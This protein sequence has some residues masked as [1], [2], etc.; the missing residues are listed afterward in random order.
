[1]SKIPHDEPLRDA[2]SRDLPHQAQPGAAS[3]EDDEIDLLALAGTLWRGRLWIALAVALGILLA[4]YYAYFQTTSVYSASTTVALQREQPQVVDFQSVVSGVSTDSASM[5]TEIEIMRSA[6]LLT[7]VA[8]ALDLPQYP[9][10][11]PR[12]REEPT[13][14]LGKAVQ[15]V[16]ELFGDANDAVVAP[17]N[18]DSQLLTAANILRS[19]IDISLLRSSYVFRIQATSEDRELAARLANTLAEFYIRDQLTLKQEATEEATDWLST[20]VSEL[21]IELEQAVAAVNTFRA[22]TNLASTEALTGLN[23]Q[24]RDLRSRIT[25]AR[26]EV[27]SAAAR[28]AALDAASGDPAAFADLAA[29]PTL[30]RIAATGEADGD[31]FE[32]RATTVLERAEAELARAEAQLGTLER[33]A[34]QVDSQISDQSG[35][36][37]QL[38]QLEREAEASRLIYEHFLSRLKETS[39][40]QGIQQA[41][42]RL[43]SAANVPGRPSAPNR[44]RIIVLGAILGL[45]IGAGLILLREMLQNTFRTTEDLH[46]KTGYA[47]MGTLPRLAAKNRRAVLD[48]VSSKPNSALAEAVRNLRTSLL[49]SNV[50]NPPKTVMLTSSTP[51]EGKTTASILLAQNLADLGKRVLLI[52]GDLRRRVFAEYFDIKGAKGIV[53]ILSGEACFEETVVRDKDTGVDLL[54]AERPNVN[55]ADLYASDRFAGFIRECEAAYDYVIIDTP[56]VLAVPD[57]RVIGRICD[58]ALYVVLWDVTKQKQ[59]SQG[60]DLLRSVGVPIA[61]TI[62]SRVDPKGMKRY[63]YEGYGYGYGKAYAGYY[64]N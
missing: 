21:K 49:L 64:E 33:S 4:G 34:A 28:L 48:Y 31:L 45:M 39:V 50:D 36:L 62:L 24:A 41:D 17:P 58:A 35:D 11:A 2:R 51:G 32:T 18:R 6:Q 14:S 63:G 20:R 54:I 53:S 9:E 44:S 38:Q 55:A 13:F 59:V 22:Q 27:E 16:R 26:A 46:T 56:P 57:A 30:S 29:D 42:V 61:G 7:R 19:K 10:F 5:N 25:A 40:Q 23:A 47:V 43:L 8:D 12:L 60:L 3:E 1:M 52:E 15:W 37:V